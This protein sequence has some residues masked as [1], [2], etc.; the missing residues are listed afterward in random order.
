[1]FCLECEW[2]T[3]F[4]I[5]GSDINHISNAKNAHYCA[6]LCLRNFACKSWTFGVGTNCWLKN[7]EPATDGVGWKVS[8]NN[9]T[10]GTKAC[11][12]SLFLFQES[13]TANFSTSVRF[14]FSIFRCLFLHQKFTK[15]SSLP[16]SVIKTS[17]TK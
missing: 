17:K 6:L 16:K 12:R 11:G 7:R 13:M 4:D 15:P 2:W 5:P 9:L 3:N 14:E 1:M 10:S 8:K